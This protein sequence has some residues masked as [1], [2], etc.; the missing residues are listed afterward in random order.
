M[1]I[2]NIDKYYI[3]YKLDRVQTIAIIIKADFLMINGSNA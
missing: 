2:I 1:L 3:R